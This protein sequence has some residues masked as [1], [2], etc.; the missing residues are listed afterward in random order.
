MKPTLEWLSDP[1]VFQVNRCPAHSDHKFYQTL[2]EMQLGQTSLKQSLNGVWQFSYAQ[3][4]A[5]AQG[6]FLQKGL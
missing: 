4:P 2:R 6:G 1:E 3:K 5:G